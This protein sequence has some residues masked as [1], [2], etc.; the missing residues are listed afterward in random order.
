MDGVEPRLEAGD[1]Q[2][3]LARELVGDTGRPQADPFGNG[4]K[5]HAV[6]ALAVQDGDCGGDYVRATALEPGARGRSRCLILG[7]PCHDTY[8]SRATRN[9][10]SPHNRDF[11]A[12]AII[13]KAHFCAMN[14]GLTK[15]S[16]CWLEPCSMVSRN[17]QGWTP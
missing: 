9:R 7:L 1:R 14:R 3:L 8:A 13:G 10:L 2:F 5:V 6:E 15:N 16:A 11:R 4:R 17:H 12:A